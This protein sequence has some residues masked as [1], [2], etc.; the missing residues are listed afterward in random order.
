MDDLAHDLSAR[1]N[2]WRAF[3]ART[4]ARLRPAAV[5][6][7]LDGR[8]LSAHSDESHAWSTLA[9]SGLCDGP[10]ERKLVVAVTRH[11]AWKV[12]RLV[13]ETVAVVD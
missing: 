7:T 9:T 8:E 6:L 10:N 11:W 13:E 5:T 1:N 2:R 12:A 4:L 3:H